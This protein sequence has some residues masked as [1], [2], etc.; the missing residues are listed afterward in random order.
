VDHVA[1]AGKRVLLAEDDGVARCIIAKVLRA[2]GP[3][4]IESADGGRM[5]A[6][7]ASFDEEDRTP[8]VLGGRTGLVREL[9]G[10]VADAVEQLSLMPSIGGPRRSFDSATM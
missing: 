5:L 3:G 2:M 4:V 6:P 8:D 7:V 1:I 10:S 9:I